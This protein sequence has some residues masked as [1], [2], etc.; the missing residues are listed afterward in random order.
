[1][2]GYVGVQSNRRLKTMKAELEDKLRNKYPKILNGTLK[3]HIDTG[4]G[5]YNLLD[6]LDANIQNTI[7]AHPE[8]PQVQ[9]IRIKEQFGGLRFV[10]IGGNREIW[11]LINMAEIKSIHICEKCGKPGDI[12][13]KDN[14]MRCLCP[15]HKREAAE[16][17]LAYELFNL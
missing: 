7:D 5:W 11:N 15:A 1:M 6:L 10:Y 13:I 4:D 17:K 3:G 9:A 8:I 12:N 16:E 14:L 2:A